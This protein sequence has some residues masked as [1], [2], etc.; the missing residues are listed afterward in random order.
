[1][2]KINI[3][4]FIAAR[5]REKGLTQEELA[6][7]LGVSKPAVSKWESGQSYPDIMLLPVLASY[8]NTSIDELVGY[9]AQMTKTDIRK[10]YERLAAAFAS[11]P[12]DHVHAEIQE[13]VRKYHSCWNLLYAAALLLVNHSMLAGGP[14][15]M[16]EILREA[17]G[18]LESVEKE[19]GD[20]SLAKVALSLRAYCFLALG[21]PAAVIDLLDDDDASQSS[22][23][24]LL[25]KA[26]AMKGDG[27]RAKLI[28][29][30]FVYQNGVNAFAAIPDLM[31]LCAGE[32]SKLDECLRLALDI[33]AALDIR[34]TMPHQYFT[35]YLTAA[36][37]YASA[38]M[39]S[40]ALD[41]LE[42]YADIATDDT[43]YP[44]KLRGNAFFD[45]LEEYID[46][47]SLG[48]KAPRNEKLI[49]KDLKGAVINNP[50]FFSLIQEER[51]RRLVSRL[52]HFE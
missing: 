28:L 15:R 12:F 7:Y 38:Q 18:L 2:A 47:L 20:I 30:R 36:A 37:L 13:Y 26:Y 44:L 17:A 25:A 35:L 24:I 1:M 23:E 40:R 39:N 43:I 21:D 5:R 52:E 3:G 49:K 33:G 29:Q 14:D 50:A 45:R 31:V 51:Y 34:G 48:N 19:S 22:P 41:M 6:E 8:F 9:E 32:I 46:T 16:N 27:D 10:L 11:E 42:A 4:A